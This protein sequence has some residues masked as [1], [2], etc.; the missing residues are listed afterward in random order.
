MGDP[1]NGWFI[2]Q[3]PLNWM[4]WGI[5]ILGNHR[6]LYIIC[7]YVLQY[8]YYN[9]LSHD[10]CGLGGSH[11]E[12]PFHLPVASPTFRS[13]FTKS[14]SSSSSKMLVA[15]RPDPPK[16]LGPPAQRGPKD[17]KDP[18]AMRRR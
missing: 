16:R 6:I 1:K 10:C 5:P 2:I 12:G 11:F 7:T 8:I 4:M 3:I 15:M 9:I 18:T 14:S 17:P 13:C